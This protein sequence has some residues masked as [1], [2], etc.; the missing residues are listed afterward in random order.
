[1]I[2]ESGYMARHENVI[3]A[4]ARIEVERGKR[5]DA[6]SDRFAPLD[7][8]AVNQPTRTGQQTGGGEL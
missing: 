2:G 5:P 1:M 6:A 8:Q 3:D 4:A 7:A